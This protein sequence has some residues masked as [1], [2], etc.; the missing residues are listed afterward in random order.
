M[1]TPPEEKKQR[2]DKKDIGVDKKD[3][4]QMEKEKKEKARIKK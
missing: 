1:K 4:V 3:I 2:I